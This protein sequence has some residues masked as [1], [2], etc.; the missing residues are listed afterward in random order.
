MACKLD[1]AR[2][3]ISK[4]NPSTSIVPVISPLLFCINKAS[5]IILLLAGFITSPFHA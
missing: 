1:A 4:N 2:G 3:C 5:P